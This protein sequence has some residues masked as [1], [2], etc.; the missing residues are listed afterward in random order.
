MLWLNLL[1]AHSLLI[2][3]LYTALRLNID[4]MIKR[5]IELGE[6]DMDLARF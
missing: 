3:T 1:D 2:Y 5:L 4:G 6:A